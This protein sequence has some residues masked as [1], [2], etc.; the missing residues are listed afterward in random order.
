VKKSE[1]QPRVAYSS[2]LVKR[3]E[4]AVGA[5]L[6]DVL[7][8]LGITP[9]QYGVLQALVRLERASSAE[10]ARA[11]FVTPQAMTGLIAGLERQRYI[12]RKPLKSSRVI[13]ATLTPLGRRVFDEATERVGRIDAQLVSNLSGDEVLALHSALERC[14]DAFE[15]DGESRPEAP[16][17]LVEEQTARA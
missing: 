14:V 2:W 11:V 4:R 13:E 17:D 1:Y 15:S 3:A 9:S 6:Y 10:L 16:D 12:K 5:A 7:R 8:D